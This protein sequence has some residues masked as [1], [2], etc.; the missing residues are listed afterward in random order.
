MNSSA[1][2]IRQRRMK[3]NGLVLPILLMLTACAD[4]NVPQ[5]DTIRAAYQQQEYAR[6]TKL[7]AAALKERPSDPTLL[8]LSGQI[9]LETGNLDFAKAQMQ[10][11]LPDTQFGARARVEL[12]R[13]YMLSG[14]PRE[15]L[16]TLGEKPPS[17]LGYSLAATAASMLGDV[18]KGGRLMV[19]GM[20]AFP[21]SSELL[22]L[23]GNNAVGGGDLAAAKSWADKAM[24]VAPQ[25]KDVRMLAA[26][27]ALAQ[28]KQSEAAQHLDVILRAHP[29][30]GL[31]LMA[32]AGILA[33]A[34]NAKA[35]EALFVKASGP[36]KNATNE[37]TA[38]ARYYRAQIAF[39][40]GNY[41]AARDIL[42]GVSPAKAFLPA[43]RLAG[44][45]AAYQGQDE[46]AIDLLRH[47]LGQGGDDPLARYALA[48]SLARVGQVADAWR[49][50]KPAALAADA[51]APVR[52]LAA[53]LTR[54]LKL[55]EAARFAPVPQ[56]PD[57]VMPSDLALAASRALQA[58]DIPKADRLF[59]EA[60]MRDPQTKDRVLLNNA[61]LVRQRV[62]DLEGSEKLARQAFALDPNDPVLMD[63]LGWILF[64]KKG[65][66]PEARKLILS[67]A[68]ALPNDREVQQHAQALRNAG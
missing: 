55:P 63:T 57:G 49:Y 6:A 40:A 51:N 52:A 23:A 37:L 34:G 18:D 19:E 11:L 8:F 20:G 21:Q 67:A 31:A 64:Q 33:R 47:Y 43:A 35:A 65:P 5:T 54:A 3:V 62:G 14:N 28:D 17:G 4:D 59:R 66:T 16:S 26:R 61:A 12:A 32:K 45:L 53:Q 46:Q 13:V 9:A 30:D 25:D 15:V 1:R 27:L 39:D 41:G 50:L 68:K 29:N 44:I 60:L 24:Q 58:G 38:A 2:P 48:I 36:G 7:V 42:A 56:T 10:R 22:V